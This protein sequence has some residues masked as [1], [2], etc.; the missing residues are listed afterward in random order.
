MAGR[1]ASAW[2]CSSSSTPALTELTHS[3]ALPMTLAS[4]TSRSFSV[5]LNAA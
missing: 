3:Q 2:K 5:F 1:T 4:I